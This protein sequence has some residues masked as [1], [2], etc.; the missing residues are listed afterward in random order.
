MG[1]A[2][3]H[4]RRSRLLLVLGACVV[5]LVAIWIYAASLE[6]WGDARTVIF[7]VGPILLGAVG[8]G[9]LIILITDVVRERRTRF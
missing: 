8:L 6:H 5:T 7:T 2:R 9:A 4:G 1:A 3:S